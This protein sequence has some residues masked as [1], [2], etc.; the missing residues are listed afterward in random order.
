MRARYSAYW[1]F[2]I[3]PFSVSWR[4]ALSVEHSLEFVESDFT[5]NARESIVV[6]EC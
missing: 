6:V 2:K 4:S 1:G 5:F 3:M